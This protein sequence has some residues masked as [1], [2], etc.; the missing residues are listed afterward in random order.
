M[1]ALQP[2]EQRVVASAVVK[3]LGNAT[4][5]AQNDVGDVFSPQSFLTNWNKLSPQAKQVL[6][7][8]DPETRGNLDQLAKVT[9]NLREGSKFLANPSGT[10]NALLHGTAMLGALQA[11]ATGNLHELGAIGAGIGSANLGARLMTNPDFVKWLARN[12]TAPIGVLPAQIGY[13]D[14]LGQQKKDPDLT[15]AAQMLASSGLAT[16]GSP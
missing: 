13:L 9:S 10:S 16:A 6:F 5:S 14:Q 2:D 3:R 8:A 1:S 7:Q 11:M 4:N 15:S 12:T